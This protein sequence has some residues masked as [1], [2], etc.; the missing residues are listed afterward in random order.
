MWNRSEDEEQVFCFGNDTT[1][2]E[3][4]FVLSIINRIFVSR[5]LFVPSVPWLMYGSRVRLPGIMAR[6]CGNKIG[7]FAA[8]A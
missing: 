3:S 5:Y 2:I 8:H 6:S 7:T 4:I 1:E